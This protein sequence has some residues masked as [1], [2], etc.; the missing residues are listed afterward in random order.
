VIKPLEYTQTYSTCFILHTD[1]ASRVVSWIFS[2][3]RRGIEGI[4]V[5]TCGYSNGDRRPTEVSDFATYKCRQLNISR[6][7]PN[8]GRLVVL[9]VA[10]KMM[11]AKKATTAKWRVE[12]LVLPIQALQLLYFPGK[13][14]SPLSLNGSRENY[15]TSMTRLC[16][17]SPCHHRI[18]SVDVCRSPEDQR[19][20]AY[21]YNTS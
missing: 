3:G 16:I 1:A 11:Q 21:S 5:C 9:I 14:Q 18:A 15:S 13:V 20:K 4:N 10:C 12:S 6:D 8:C 7:L 19:P 17:P 2:L